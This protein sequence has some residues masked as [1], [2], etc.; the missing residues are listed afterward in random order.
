MNLGIKGKKALITGGSRGLGLASAVSLAKEGVDLAI[1]ARAKSDLENAKKILS[2]YHVKI[3]AINFDLSDNKKLES[4]VQETEKQ[5]GSIDILVNNVGGS[6][7]TSSL[8]ETNLE[9]FQKVMELNTWSAIELTKSILPKMILSKWGRIINIAS[10]YGREYGGSAP[11]MA[12][13]AA[14]IAATKHTALD[15]AKTGVTA[16]CI[17]PG[18]IK[19]A[20][21][22][23]EKFVLNNSKKDVETFIQNNL[24]MGKFGF[25]EAIGDTVS[26]LASKNASMILGTCLNVD[27]GQSSNLF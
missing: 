13:K 12:A 16:N 2:K 6:L 10:I 20:K 14:L 22:S 9:D 11:Y 23:W 1:C 4:L 25:P 3:C 19:H 27:G 7:G 24:P 17:A 21:G 18:S 26:F 8:I 5:L 15:I